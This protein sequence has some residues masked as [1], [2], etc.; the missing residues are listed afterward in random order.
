MLLDDS[1]PD[2][3][4]ERLTQDGIAIFLFHGVI[5]R[6]RH[7]VRNYT[8]KHIEAGLFA[9]CMQRIAREGQAQSMNEVLRRCE[10]GEPFPARSFAVTFDDGFENNLSVAAPILADFAIPATIYVTSGFIEANGMS[11][12][13]RIECVIEDAPARTLRVDWAEEPF[14]LHDA[15]SRIEFLK[16][17]R[18]HVKNDSGCDANAFADA[19][20]EQ[21]GM[22]GG[23]PASTDPLDLKMTW[24]QVR[25][26]HGS[27]LLTVGGHSH[28]H[29]ILSFL[30]HERLSIELDTSLALLDRRAGVGPVHY[31]YPEGLAH[32]Y[33]HTVIQELKNRGVRCC[34][35][36][37][38][39]INAAGADPFHLRRI[40]I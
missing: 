27:D 30:S 21:L 25:A 8:G 32:C 31:S 38:D 15:A 12:I 24:E 4:V 6:Q 5:P 3:M 11:W 13:D 7:R 18:R 16:A 10:N 1:L 22:P 33:S 14:H 37:I 28:T 2:R 20:C 17:V 34:P 9:R 40:M 35:T 23:P 19:L 36:A 39:G 26:A 29:P